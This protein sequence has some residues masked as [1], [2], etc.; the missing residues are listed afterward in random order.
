M[1]IPIRPGPP[2]LGTK[3]IP[4]SDEGFDAR[5]IFHK[6]ENSTNNRWEGS[7]QKMVQRDLL[8][9]ISEA[10]AQTYKAGEGTRFPE[11]IEF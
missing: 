2:R 11:S 4:P 8:S 9:P 1:S 5:T 7:G 10:K 6:T 3:T